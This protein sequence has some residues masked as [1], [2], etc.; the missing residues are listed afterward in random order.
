MS[1]VSLGLLLAFASVSAL[2][3]RDLPIPSRELS[4]VRPDEIPATYVPAR[5]TVLLALALSLAESIGAHDLFLGANAIDYSG[6]PDC[7]PE[8]LRAFEAAANLGTRAGVEGATYRVRAPLLRIQAGEDP[9]CIHAFTLGGRS[10]APQGRSR[11]CLR[12]LRHLL[13]HF[14]D[15]GVT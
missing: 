10:A 5:N 7:R 4:E 3:N 2:T 1:P 12:S 14:A 15:R 8:F 6:Y 13:H 11:T 9:V